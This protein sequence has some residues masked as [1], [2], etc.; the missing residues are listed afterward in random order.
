MRASFVVALTVFVS[1]WSIGNVG[2]AKTPIESHPETQKLLNGILRTERSASEYYRLVDELDVLARQDGGRFIRQI[3]LHEIES[4]TPDNLFPAAY[5]LKYVSIPEGHYAVGLSTLLYSEDVKTREY[6]RE[7]FPLAIGRQC[8]GGQP[9]LSHIRDYV[10]GNYQKPE[11]ATPLKRAIF[12]TMPSAAFIMYVRAEGRKESREEGIAL[13][14][15]ERTINNALYE[16]HSLGGIPSGKIDDATAAALRDLGQSKRWWS[17]LYAAEVMVQNKEFRD[18]EL[19][20][21]LLN[22][23]HDLVRQSIASI[24][25]PDTLRR[26]KVDE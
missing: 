22:D 8:V 4:T 3:V 24:Q 5:L 20:E 19:I 23:E 21:T 12:E 18:A 1:N 11:I 25:K 13:L 6:A 2:C 16:K 17:R 10:T 15:K 26:T 14:R 7:L 9:D